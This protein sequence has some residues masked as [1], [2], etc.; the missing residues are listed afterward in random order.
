[1]LILSLG[2]VFLLECRCF[3]MLVCLGVM[4]VLVNVVMNCSWLLLLGLVVLVRVYSLLVILRWVVL[5]CVGVM[6]RVVVVCSCVSVVCIVVDL[7]LW[8]MLLSM[9]LM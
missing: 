1:M 3:M 2:S 5:C 8:L 6:Y 9:R 7:V 4:S